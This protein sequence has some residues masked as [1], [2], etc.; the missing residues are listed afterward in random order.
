M[1]TVVRLGLSPSARC[2]QAWAATG[3]MS[4]LDKLEGEVT[5]LVLAA[6]VIAATAALIPPLAEAT[7][8]NGALSRPFFGGPFWFRPEPWCSSALPSASTGP[9]PVRSRARC[10]SWRRNSSPGSTHQE[11]SEPGQGASRGQRSAGQKQC[12][13]VC[14]TK[15]AAEAAAQADVDAARRELL[16]AESKATTD[17][18]LQAP[19]WLLPAALDL[20]AFMAIWTGLSGRFK[21]GPTGLSTRRRA[22]RRKPRAPKTPDAKAQAAALVRRWANDN[23]V[24]PFTAA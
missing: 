10:S 9:R 15:L 19:V 23:V 11:R 1:S 7:W 2:V 22:A 13:P 18:P 5:Y 6:P 24:V 17:S 20:V 14:R 12:G 8:R 16:S 3:L 21:P 4:S